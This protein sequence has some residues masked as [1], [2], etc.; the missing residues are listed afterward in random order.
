M[1]GPGLCFLG[2]FGSVDCMA[3]CIK[4]VGAVPFPILVAFPAPSSGA[5]FL[6]PGVHP[7]PEEAP[8]FSCCC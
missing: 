1:L 4:T 6:R 7:D 5:S 2:F 8:G 3:F